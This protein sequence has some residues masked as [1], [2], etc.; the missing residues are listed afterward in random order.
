[1]KTSPTHVLHAKHDLLVG[2]RNGLFIGVCLGCGKFLGASKRLRVL[3]I[4]DRYHHCPRELGFAGLKI[5]S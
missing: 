3:H 2:K 4:A 5:S 1:M